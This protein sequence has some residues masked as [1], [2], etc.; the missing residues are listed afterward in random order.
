MD[1]KN[2]RF[3]LV[4]RTIFLA[5]SIFA[6]I[7]SA[8]KNEWYVTQIATAVI[9]LGFL[10][11]IIRYA[12]KYKRGLGDFLLSIKS[13]DFISSVNALS[14]K[15]SKYILKEAYD[16]I[17]SEF[18]NI[19][20]DKEVQYHYLK[21]I[22]EHI[23]I[24]LFSYNEFGEIQFINK[25][26]SK[27]LNLTSQHNISQIKNQDINL[28]NLI[29]R[30]KSG[31]KELVKLK[32]NDN[33]MHLSMFATEFKVQSPPAGR[34]GKSIKLISLQNI[35]QE[36]EYQELESWQKLIRV[37]T[38]EIMNSVTPISSLSN[39]INET[40]ENT[41]GQKSELAKISDD[42]FE[43]ILSSLKTIENR[44]KGLLKFVSSYKQLTRIPKPDFKEV[45]L[46]ELLNH[47][48]TLLKQNIS[49]NKINFQLNCAENIGKTYADYDQIEQVII[50]LIINAIEAVKDQ[51]KPQISIDVL[52]TEFNKHKVV[53]IDNGKGID[54]DEMDKIFIPFYTTKKEG[55]GIGLSLSRQIMRLH[56]GSI[57]VNSELGKGSEFILEF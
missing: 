6:T 1:F 36:L 14:D 51:V 30:L 17:L 4:L 15:N 23:Q 45:N 57:Q 28:Y 42:D 2:F 55:S 13:R 35:K 32:L 11:E 49:E 34:A 43:D 31:E 37:L 52:R 50:N 27:L 41:N 25:T 10:I 5:L 8:Y 9:S 40:F 33:L 16:T 29:K 3:G 53:V 12:E 26:A 47:C 38:H 18:Q 48:R 20:I 7:F 46:T 19:R 22:V 44:S 24:A 54:P 56:K 21:T 39:A